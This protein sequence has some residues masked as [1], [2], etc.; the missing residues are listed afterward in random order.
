MLDWKVGIIP[1]WIAVFAFA[2]LVVGLG[3]GAKWLIYH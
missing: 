1:I 3:E 2:I